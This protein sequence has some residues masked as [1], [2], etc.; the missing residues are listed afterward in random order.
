MYT[1]AKWFLAIYTMHQ[2]KI[3]RHLYLEIIK[4]REI[5]NRRVGFK[6]EMLLSQ[7]GCDSLVRVASEYFPIIYSKNK[8]RISNKIFG[9]IMRL[10]ILNEV[11]MKRDTY[12]IGSLIFCV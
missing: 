12:S 8:K 6:Q 3:Q 4:N 7:F 9:I 2:R 11:H 10:N 5:A 1:E